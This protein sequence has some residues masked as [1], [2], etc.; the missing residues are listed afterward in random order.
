VRVD[1]TLSTDKSTY[2]PGEMVSLTGSTIIQENDLAINGIT[3]SYGLS[4][5][6]ISS[7][8]LL[9]GVTGNQSYAR[10]NA[11]AAPGTPG[12]YTITLSYPTI[13]HN[14]TCTK[15]G[16]PAHASGDTTFT[17]AVPVTPPTVNIWFQ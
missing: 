12:T 14:G 11:F 16:T 7:G 13:S 9:S 4:Y 17:V 2:A 8:V 5:S 6:G 3:Y 10:P 15:I 1:A